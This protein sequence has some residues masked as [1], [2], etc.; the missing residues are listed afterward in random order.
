MQ[1]A[2]IGSGIAGLSAAHELSKRH[3]VTLYEAETRAGGHACTIDVT[4]DGITHAVDVGFLVFNERTY[5]H[6]IA[7]FEELGVEVA[8]SDMSFSVSVRP[9]GLEWNGSTL[10]TVFA[11]PSNLASPRF[12]RMLADIM[13]FNRE[14]TALANGGVER[15]LDMPLGRWLA[16]TGYGKEFRDWYLLP[17]AAAI[18]SCPIAVMEDFPL[19]SFVR[20]FHN[21]GLLQVRDRPQWY[22]VRG[23]SRRYV[24]AV[25][26]SIA[27]VRLGTPVRRIARRMNS[28]VPEVTVCTDADA[29]RF[30]AVVLATHSPQA[31]ALLEAPSREEREILG[32]IRTQSN[33]AWLH[34]DTAL[35][36]VRRRAWAAWNYLSEGGAAPSDRAVSV[37]YW[38]NRLQPLP[39][40]T[41]VLVSL[42]PPR[43]PRAERQIRRIEFAHPVFDREAVAAQKRLDALQGHLG[44]YS[45][46]AWHGYG[47]HE[48]GIASARRMVG[49]LESRAPTL[50]QAA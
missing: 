45:C 35:M 16:A 43:P 24:E 13:R 38:I 7:L 47:F 8:P 30:D 11:Q 22:T 9:D 46:G 48:D 33:T 31:L 15:T 12:L 10:R 1:I 5:P 29:T 2:V 26:R 28:G 21:H 40:E 4:L 20:F 44:T 3:E 25:L 6:L 14:A 19:G 49:L 41:P 27:R 34:T 42:N 39:F 37:S 36:P 50:A 18:W 17:M 32:A 23:G